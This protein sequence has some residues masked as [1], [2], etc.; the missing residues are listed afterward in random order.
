MHARGGALVRAWQCAPAVMS[1]TA[2]AHETRIS[3]GVSACSMRVYERAPPRRPAHIRSWPGTQ[4]GTRES[5]GR[6]KRKRRHR[7][8]HAHRTPCPLAT[9]PTRPGIARAHTPSGLPPKPASPAWRTSPNDSAHRASH[10]S[11]VARTASTQV[12]NRKFPASP[13]IVS[14]PIQTCAPQR[15]CATPPLLIHGHSAMCSAARTLRQTMA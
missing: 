7:T 11:R 15:C 13:G 9:T 1:E 4:H 6:R 10:A 14:H 5:V 12:R 2:R 3:P 8:L